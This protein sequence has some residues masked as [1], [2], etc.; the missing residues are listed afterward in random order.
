M[1]SGAR[2]LL[3][4]S[5][6]ALLEAL[7]QDPATGLYRLLAGLSRKGHRIIL[8]APE[9]ERWVPTRR[10]VDQ[11]LVDQQSLVGEV[12]AAGGDLDGVYYVPRSLLTQDRNRVGALRDILRRYGLEPAAAILLSSSAP[13]L[14]AAQSLGLATVEIAIAG[15][16]GTRLVTALENLAGAA[17]PKASGN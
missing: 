10:H 5:R 4:I 12:R 2:P 13:F 9:P 6:D 11:A 15:R 3:I 16:P 17:G 1:V 14:K 7:R 8:T